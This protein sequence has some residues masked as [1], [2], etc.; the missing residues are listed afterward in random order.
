MATIL[1]VANIH[2][3]LGGSTRVEH[4]IGDNVVR[5]NA[6]AVKLSGGSTSNRP[7]DAEGLI[8]YNSEYGKFEIYESSGWANVTSNLSTSQAGAAANDF[9][10]AILAA[11][12]IIIG[13][14]ANTVGSKAYDK[15]NA[16]NVLAF[17]VSGAVT[18]LNVTVAYANSAW[19][20]ANAANV[21]AFNAFQNTTATLAGS[22]TTTG[23]VSDNKGNVRVIP[24]NTQTS[25]Y[26][27]VASDI[28]KFISIT[29]GGV[30]VPA[31]I[32]NPGDAIS[33]YNNSTA[34]QTIT[35]GASVTMYLGGTAL[36]GNRTIS[37]RGIATI[38]CIA[39]TYP[40]STFVISG[41]G[42]S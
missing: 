22:L 5:V 6:K 38:L 3:D 21:L 30:T 32:F 39:N 7:P 23:T 2:F 15:A 8:R 17:Q 14:G 36:M 37:Q 25:A 24:V 42:V 33:I 1:T 9:A 27:L 28:G 16:A 13:T 31:S 26:T 20:K 35:Q 12:S 41:A 40:S 34:P 18:G 19:D 4:I 29:T 10:L 11:N